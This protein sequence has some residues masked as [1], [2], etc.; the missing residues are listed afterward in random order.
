MVAKRA[1]YDQF[2]VKQRVARVV[3]GPETFVAR[4]ADVIRLAESHSRT[5]VIAG[6]GYP[7]CVNDA[8]GPWV[9]DRLRGEIRYPVWGTS[10]SP[11]TNSNFDQ[12]LQRLHQENSNAYVIGIDSSWQNDVSRWGEI[13]LVT[14]RHRMINRTFGSHPNRERIASVILCYLPSIRRRPLSVR[15][16]TRYV[17]VCVHLIV[18]AVDQHRIRL[19]GCCS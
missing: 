16:V 12:Q 4:L 9:A 10:E 19:D 3:D 6:I 1:W 2:G 7:K 17:D 14:D 11:I 18:R 15:Q 8:F 13:E 5:V